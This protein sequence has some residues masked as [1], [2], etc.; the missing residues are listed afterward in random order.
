MKLTL[1]GKTYESDFIALIKVSIGEARVLKSR[2]RGPDGQRGM[3]IADW[4][5]GLKN[6]DRADPDVLAALAF[7]L[8]HRAG[9]GGGGDEINTLTLEDLTSALD[10]TLTNGDREFIAKAGAKDWAE[11]GAVQAQAGD[12]EQV[13][14]VKEPAADSAEEPAKK[15]TEEPAAR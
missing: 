14:P 8:R 3:T 4:E 15:P 7:L 6:L 5:D 10:F 12:G 2:F 9:E 13:V 11:L 1:G